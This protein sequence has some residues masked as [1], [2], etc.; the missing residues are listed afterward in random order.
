MPIRK[1]LRHLYR[2]PAWFGLRLNVLAEAG[3]R[4][5]SCKRPNNRLTLSCR[6]S[7]GRWNTTAVDSML[8]LP[9][10]VFP[11][12]YRERYP[13][14]DE[15]AKPAR[16]GQW[17]TVEELFYLQQ[18]YSRF[19]RDMREWYGP[20]YRLEKRAPMPASGRVFL[21][22]TR[23]GIAHLDYN[24]ENMARSNLG[25]LCARCHLQHDAK[26]HNAEARRT[27]S[28][29]RGQLWLS[30]DLEHATRPVTAA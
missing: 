9:W 14:A 8:E 28:A 13:S 26:Q 22:L 24:P 12:T 29:R 23:I 18:T 21:V 3:D 27:I 30:Q 15:L 20:Q 16:R 7:S 17:F 6:D 2:G 25:A 11:E 4:C 1:E 10:A 5:E 19:S